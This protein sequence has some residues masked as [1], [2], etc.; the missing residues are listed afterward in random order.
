MQP[1]LESHWRAYHF[2]GPSKRWSSE[3]VVTRNSPRLKPI[4]G[5]RALIL[6]RRGRTAEDTQAARYAE[7]VPRSRRR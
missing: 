7:A 4:T 3:N 2:L 6:P 1:S 5:E